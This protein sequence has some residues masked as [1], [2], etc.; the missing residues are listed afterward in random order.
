[1]AA[2]DLVRPGH[3]TDATGSARRE[4]GT[5]D[6]LRRGE[7]VTDDWRLIF[8]AYALAVVAIGAA[9]VFFI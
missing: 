2:G 3:R 1:M 6:V 9:I 8:V 7:A 4:L 5:R